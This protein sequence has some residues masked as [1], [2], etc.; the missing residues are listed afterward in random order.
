MRTSRYV[1]ENYEQGLV[2]DYWEGANTVNGIANTA[3]MPRLE[4]SWGH[5]PPGIWQPLRLLLVIVLLRPHLVVKA[6]HVGIATYWLQN[7]CCIWFGVHV[8]VLLLMQDHWNAILKAANA[9]IYHK[10]PSS[11]QISRSR[12]GEYLHACNCVVDYFIIKCS[13]ILPLLRVFTQLKQS[14]VEHTLCRHGV[15]VKGLHSM[16]IRQP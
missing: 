1:N 6:N 16:Y 13:S 10:L 14:S 5:A 3:C 2:Q 4:G 12:H 9:K 11:N 7:Y 15:T 8:I